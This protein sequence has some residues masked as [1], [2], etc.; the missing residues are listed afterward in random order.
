MKPVKLILLVLA[1][2]LACQLAALPFRDGEKLVFNVKYGLVSA[3]EVVME[4]R[5]STYQGLPVWYLKTTAQTYPFFDSVFKVR[6]NIESWWD[7][8]TL[9]PHKFSKI[10]QEGK[11]RQ[12]RIHIYNQKEKLTTFQKWI[13]RENQWKTEELPLQVPTQDALSV[14]YHIR[15]LDL[16]PGRTVRVNVTTDGRSVS[17]EVIVH[18]RESIS[19]IFGKINCLVVEP[20]LRGEA[21]FNQKGNMLF[22]LTDD[23]Y[24]LPVQMESDVTIGKFL[25]RL[26]DAVKAPYVIKYPEK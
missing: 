4:A 12:R 3:G 25:I 17:S 21:M 1:L 15:T 24:K 11:Y 19:T 5:S 9:T 26:K 18:R 20:R 7:K 6:D 23:Q 8:Q 14:I 2:S 16:V 22:W 10:L 13:F